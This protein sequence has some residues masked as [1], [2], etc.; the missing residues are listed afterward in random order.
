MC[1]PGV[2]VAAGSLLQAEGQYKTDES[3]EAILEF[4][5][6]SVKQ[7]ADAEAAALESQAKEEGIRAKDA[8]KRGRFRLGR[9]T[10][11]TQLDISSIKAALSTTGVKT[12]VGSPQRIVEDQRRIG[13]QDAIILSQNTALEVF[14]FKTRASKFRAGAELVRKRGGAQAELFGKQVTAIRKTKGI[15]RFATLLTGFGQGIAI[16]ISTFGGGGGGEK[17]RTGGDIRTPA[18]G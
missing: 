4:Q 2:L 15:R 17:P 9:L 3:N 13:V 5:Q 8:Q 12:T 10:K 1:T 16:D 14:G 18:K 7:Q 11:Q 6:E